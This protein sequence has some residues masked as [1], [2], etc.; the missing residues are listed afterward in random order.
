MESNKE[1]SESNVYKKWCLD[2]LFSTMYGTNT[3][4]LDNLLTIYLHLETLFC[5][6]TQFPVWRTKYTPIILKLKP[7]ELKL[8]SDTDHNSM[9]LN[10]DNVNFQDDFIK[11]T[12]RSIIYCNPYTEHIA[13]FTFWVNEFRRTIRNMIEIYSDTIVLKELKRGKC[14]YSIGQLRS[15]KFKV[16]ILDE[17]QCLYITYAVKFFIMACTT[18]KKLDTNGC[19]SIF[20]YQDDK[21]KLT[22]MNRIVERVPFV[23]ENVKSIV[24]HSNQSCLVFQSLSAFFDNISPIVD[25]I[26][27]D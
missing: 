3:D 22:H 12:Q 4:L 11:R 19:S 20:L 13:Q 8:L 6:V 27:V 7:R 25:C 16:R 18:N 5:K 15:L 9:I 21:T 1:Q 26:K 2:F 14:N 10:E 23:A 24:C 17:M